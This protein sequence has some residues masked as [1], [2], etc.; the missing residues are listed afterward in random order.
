[1]IY[2]PVN[3][4]EVYVVHSP[5]WT[6]TKCCIGL[7]GPNDVNTIFLQDQKIYDDEQSA[8]FALW[9]CIT[10]GEQGD[11]GWL[12]ESD[13]PSFYPDGSVKRETMYALNIGT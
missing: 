8:P 4:G 5:S 7:I 11:T 6:K 9:M 10:S 3:L 1:M 12:T 13:L 2:P